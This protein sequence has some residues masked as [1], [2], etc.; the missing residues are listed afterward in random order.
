MEAVLHA[1]DEAGMIPSLETHN[2]VIAAYITA[3]MWDRMESTYQAMQAGTVKPELSTHLLMLR[4]YAHSG[5]IEKMEDIYRIVSQQ[6]QLLSK[7]D[8]LF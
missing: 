6:V 3:F 7:I 1:A 2:T 8:H 5:N 4:G